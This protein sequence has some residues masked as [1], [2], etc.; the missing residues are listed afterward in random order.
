MWSER[1]PI[2]T[3]VVGLTPDAGAQVRQA[4]SQL[5]LYR[6]TRNAVRIL[7]SRIRRALGRD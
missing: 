1:R 4:A 6:N 3:I 5:Q 2:G 7:R